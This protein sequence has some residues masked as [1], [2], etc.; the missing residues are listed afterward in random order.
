MNINPQNATIN[1]VQNFFLYHLSPNLII[2][3]GFEKSCKDLKYVLIMKIDFALHI[4]EKDFIFG[5]CTTKNPRVQK[6]TISGLK[7]ID[8][9][10]FKLLIFSNFKISKK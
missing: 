7:T 4:L 10:Y 1:L 6:F 2:S 3:L 8:V 9:R 5:F